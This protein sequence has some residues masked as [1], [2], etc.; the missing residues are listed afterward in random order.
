MQNSVNNTLTSVTS[1]ISSLLPTMDLYLTIF[2]M[3]LAF[4]VGL[5][6]STSCLLYFI[7]FQRQVKPDTTIKSD[8]ST[9]V[10]FPS[11]GLTPFTSTRPTPIIFTRSLEDSL[12]STMSF[13]RILANRQM[14]TLELGLQNVLTQNEQVYL[15]SLVKSGIDLSKTITDR[16]MLEKRYPTRRLFHSTLPTIVDVPEL[17][18]VHRTS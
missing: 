13:G 1:T 16:Q 18:E 2:L 6:V 9:F 3:V 5:L 14:N 4:C 15:E 12:G 8:P 7:L 17:P 10:H 11:P